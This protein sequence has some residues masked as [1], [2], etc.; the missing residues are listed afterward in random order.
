[1]KGRA[2]RSRGDDGKTT[3]HPAE[4]SSWQLASLKYIRG[5]NLQV[6]FLGSFT[7]AQ[8]QEAASVQCVEVSGS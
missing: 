2:S 8:M 5:E 6:A 7:R 4:K 3:R 1:M